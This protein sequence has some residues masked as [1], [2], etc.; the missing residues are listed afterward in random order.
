MAEEFF[1]GSWL[2]VM[3]WLVLGKDFSGSGACSACGHDGR[4]GISKY[5]F[6]LFP[7]VLSSF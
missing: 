3:G 2:V 4:Y 5:G 1:V 7:C 6:L